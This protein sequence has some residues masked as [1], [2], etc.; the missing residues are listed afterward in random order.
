MLRSIHGAIEDMTILDPTC[1]SGAFLFA[2]LNVLEPLYEACLERMQGFVNDSAYTDVDDFRSILENVD[3][4]PNRR[5]YVLK[6]IIIRNLFGVDIM[7]EAVE[8]CKLR[9]FLNLVAQVDAVEHI[10]PLPDI[11]FNIRA[12]NSLVG[13]ATYAEVSDAVTSK[14]DFE[15]SMGQIATGADGADQAFR[16]F[17]ELQVGKAVRSNEIAA[18]KDELH[19]RLH[20]LR[21]QLDAYLAG[22]YG[23]DATS[24]AKLE[25]WRASHMPFHWFVEFYGTIARGGFDVIIGNPPYVEYKNVEDYRIRGFRTESCGD[26]YGYVLERSVAL[27]APNGRVGFI[28]PM[29][30]F[31]VDKFAPVQDLFFEKTSPLFITNW[32]GDAHPSRL[33]DGVDKRLE[34]VLAKTHGDES[35]SPDVYSSKYIKWYAEE[36]PTLF[37]VAPV[38]QRLGAVKPLMMFPASVPK[39]GT[40]I[41]REVL[42]A[43]RSRR[44]RVGALV[45]TTG[46]H[47]LYYTREGVLL[48]SVPRLRPESVGLGWCAPRTVRS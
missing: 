6:S 21:S 8:I 22:D 14:L 39:I 17:R 45:G 1:G 41:E 9:L 35:R 27:A 2:A 40:D 34:I 37:R 13:F 24:A 47:S 18:A 15:D 16:N 46:R 10:E 30:C 44:R 43:L 12:G 3:A 26:L 7:E 48:S 5:Y 25:T 11:D 28:V 33:F 20:A 19:Q 38:Y 32:S 36:R 42:E 29:S 23:I 31:A 4:H